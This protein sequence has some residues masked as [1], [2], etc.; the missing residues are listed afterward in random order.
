VPASDLA[1]TVRGLFVGAL[2]LMAAHAGSASAGTACTNHPIGPRELAAASASA[3]RVYA[4]LEQSDAPVALI[5]RHG[6]DLGKY[7]LYYSHVGFAVRDRPEG[8][9]TVV[10]E[11]NFCGTDRSGLYAQGLVNF[12]ADDLVDQ[13]ARIVWLQPELARRVTA[14]LDGQQARAVHDPH[15]SVIARYNSREWQNSTAWALD[16]L[17]AAEL[18]PGDPIDRDRAQA[19]ELALGFQPDTI[20]IPY[21]QRVLGGLFSANTVFTDHP[22]SARLG[23]EYK[24]VTVRSILRWLDAMGATKRVREWRGGVETTTPGPA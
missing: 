24:V 9:W 8:R 4:A 19:E 11:L 7:G 17:A 2:V 1:R 14:I 12:F 18:P 20:H 15:Y 3:K 23:G 10:H 21:G 5:A 16:V 13:D 6:Q 22:L